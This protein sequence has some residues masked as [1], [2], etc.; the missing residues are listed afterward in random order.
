MNITYPVFLAEIQPRYVELFAFA[1]QEQVEDSLEAWDVENGEY[2]AWD[3]NG[4]LL[5]L[6]VDYALP[7]RHWLK[8]TCPGQDDLERFLDTLR[9]YAVTHP[10]EA[11]SE[12]AEDEWPQALRDEVARAL[13]EMPAKPER[14]RRWWWPW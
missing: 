8:M 12:A 7:E 2:T 4:V 13:A 14:P 5:T 9:R 10:G 1:S 3:A 11:Q 6:E